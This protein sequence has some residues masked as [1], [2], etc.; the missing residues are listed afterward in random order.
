MKKLPV[1]LANSNPWKRLFLGL[2]ATLPLSLTPP[3]AQASVFDNSGR[4]VTSYDGY[5]Y[6]PVCIDPSSSTTQRGDGANAG[7]IHAPNPSVSDVIGKVRTALSNSWEK[8]SSVRF[9]G[10]QYCNTLSATQLRESVSLFVGPGAENVTSNSSPLGARMHT[11]FAA[12]GKQ[13]N[14]CISYNWSTA[15]VEYS[16]A[17]AEQ[18]AIHELG[19]VIGFQHEWLHPR[20]P[21]SCPQNDTTVTNYGTTYPNN[22]FYTIVN[23]S[24]YDWDSIMNYWDGCVNQ[25]G[26]RFGSENLSSIDILGVATIYP[27][28]RPELVSFADVNGDR[29]ADRC[30]L[31]GQGAT[32]TIACRLTNEEGFAQGATFQSTPG[33]D[34]GYPDLPRAF[35]DVNGDRKADFCRVVGDAS[36]LLACNL[37]GTNGFASGQYDFRSISGIDLGYGDAP[38]SFADVNG[39]GKADFCRAV[40]DNN[41]FLACNLA[42]TTG[43]GANQ[44]QF[45]SIEAI[46]LGHADAPRSFADVNGDS[47][48]D[49]CRLV[50]DTNR[51]LA[52]NLAEANGFGANQYQFQ[53]IPGIDLGHAVAPRSFVDVNGDKKADF[54]RIVGNPKW[55][56]ACN[57]A[58]N[59]GF[60]SNQYLFAGYTD[61]DL[62][63]ADALRGFVD[64]N[65]DRRSDFCRTVGS[66]RTMRCQL[67]NTN[68]FSIDEF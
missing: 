17:C 14:R 23:P 8:W 64:A 6:V 28:S 65:G 27:T 43:F 55:F 67:A 31:E 21:A 40:G 20:R 2:I 63:Y 39:D 68:G 26:V 19:H 50:G 41:R 18:Y 4:W 58:E 42:E 12:W 29:R 1:E 60:G 38:R 51:F 56:L 32:K 57:L 33:I 62:G 22:F 16:F 61:T 25:T 5:T 9:I 48:A 49:F 47:K 30:Q 37:A 66:H 7:L 36:K 3:P 13:F 53:S 54:C 46:D 24:S 45:Q 52:C 34:A 10:W 59:N 44:Y 35:V 15:R 11:Q